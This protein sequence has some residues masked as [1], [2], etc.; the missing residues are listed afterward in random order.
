MKPQ[1]RSRPLGWQVIGSLGLFVQHG[2]KQLQVLIANTPGVMSW[3]VIA[4]ES[5]RDAATLEDVFDNHS[6]ASLGSVGDLAAA[7]ELAD[8][9]ATRWQ[10]TQEEPAPCACGPIEVVD[11]PS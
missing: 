9:Y 7:M 4:L 5:K 10:K 2:E 3:T 6:H 8:A 11:G 1:I